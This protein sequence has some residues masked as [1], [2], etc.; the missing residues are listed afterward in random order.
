MV[1]ELVPYRGN[2][3]PFQQIVDEVVAE[4]SQSEFPHKRGDICFLP[5]KGQGIDRVE[6]IQRPIP[7]T[8]PRRTPD[9]GLDVSAA[10]PHRSRHSHPLGQVRRNR[11]CK[12]GT[13]AHTD[14]S[15]TPHPQKPAK[16]TASG[17]ITHKPTS[18]PF[19]GY[20]STRSTP[21]LATAPPPPRSP[22]PLPPAHPPPTPS[23]H[24]PPPPCRPS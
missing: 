14:V 22:H 20:V 9:T 10:R 5:R 12:P 24:P 17:K 16:G 18:T 1:N 8:Q 4:P 6:V 15:L 19:H 13:H 3:R 2:V 21:S 23:R 11:R 7:L